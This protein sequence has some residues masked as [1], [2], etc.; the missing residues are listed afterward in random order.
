MAL[1]SS[2]TIYVAKISYEM[3]KWFGNVRGTKIVHR[4]TD[5]QT[6]TH[7]QTHTQTHKHTDTHTPRPIL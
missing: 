7:T 5:R 3:D 6:D 1:E 4:H 2:G